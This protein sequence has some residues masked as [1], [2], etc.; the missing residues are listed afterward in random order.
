MVD[1][2]QI[3]LLL[4][5]VF[6]PFYCIITRRKLLL[7]AW[8]CISV[9]VNIFDT[10]IFVN[11][12][13]ARIA[14][15]LLLPLVIGMLRS[16]VRTTSGSVLVLQYAYLAFL[17]LVFGF[18]FPWSDLGLQRSF[19][20]TATGRAAIYMVRLT[21]DLSLA[22][23]ISQQVMKMG[24]PD[25]VL[26]YI[27]VGTS[28]AA[29]GGV[30][31]FVTGVDLYGAITGLRQYTYV[32]RPTGFNFEPRGLGL[33]AGHGL[34]F[35][36]IL[37]AYQ[38][39]WQNGMLILLHAS[40]LFLAR[41]AS[42]LVVAIVGLGI[43]FLMIERARFSL[44]RFAVFS[45]PAIL[46]L[47]LWLQLASSNPLEPLLTGFSEEIALRLTTA[48][49][50]RGASNLL[51]EI[52]FRT[53]VFDGGALLFLS[54]NLVYLLIGTGP[55]L[56]SLPAT[57]YIPESV[58]YLYWVEAGAGINSPPTIGAIL[59]LSNAGIIGVLLWL[60]MVF[61][62]L[63]AFNYLQQ[64]AGP[65]DQSWALGRTA[66]AAAAAM[67]LVQAS[68]LSAIWPVFVGTALA[69]SKAASVR[70]PAQAKSLLSRRPT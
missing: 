8:I 11:L 24:R 59:E 41:S 62:A 6:V 38:R 18:L 19:N 44:L 26:K 32:L 55:G 4:V 23:F 40:A 27:L 54:D 47:W 63:R 25:K 12:P 1:S 58:Y 36:L 66:F 35:S 69:A 2:R 46:L 51:E 67:Y 28:I 60:T 42:G 68:P 17:A 20:Q 48:R 15:L 45:L 16:Q 5:A 52:V 65:K 7:L 22:F 33:I 43:V 29:V 70:I 56:V 3:V 31:A 61:S 37:Y 10:K 21:A 49:F 9:S 64:Q 13:A 30:I 14:G 34:A 57:S 53:D 39:S 50:D